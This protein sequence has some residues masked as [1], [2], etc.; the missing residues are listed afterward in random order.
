MQFKAESVQNNPKA[1][2][3]SAI[4]AGKLVPS[5]NPFSKKRRHDEITKENTKPAANGSTPAKPQLDEEDASMLEEQKSALSSD[6][7]M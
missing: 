2:K 7:K 1:S 5:A 6:V 4:S 3:A